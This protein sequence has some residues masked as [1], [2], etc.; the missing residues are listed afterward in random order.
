MA[1]AWGRGERLL[2]LPVLAPRPVALLVPDFSI[3]TA[4]AYG[5]LADSRGGYAPEGQVIGPDALATW[6]G[7]IGIAAND[8]DDVVRARYPIIGDLVG[9]LEAA[10]ADIAMLSGSGSTVF[11]VFPSEDAA[12]SVHCPERVRLAVTQTSERVVRVESNK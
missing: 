8:F 11:G 6:E 4:D 10:G 7:M 12:R 9:T 2:P 5:W 1:L 3:G